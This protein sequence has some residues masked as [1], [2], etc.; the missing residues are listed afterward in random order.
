MNES[1]EPSRDAV[2]VTARLG[3]ISPFVFVSDGTAALTEESV[4][5]YETVTATLAKLQGWIVETLVAD[6]AGFAALMARRAAGELAWD[7]VCPVAA[8]SGRGALVRPVLDGKRPYTMLA[9]AGYPCWAADRHIYTIDLLNPSNE[10]LF[11]YGEDGR[12]LWSVIPYPPRFR[13]PDLV[14]SSLLK[15]VA[16]TLRAEY[17]FGGLWVS[18]AA[19]AYVFPDE[20]KP[21]SRPLHDMVFPHVIARRAALGPDGLERLGKG[22]AVGSR[23]WTLPTCET[24]GDESE[25]VFISCCADYGDENVHLGRAVA[26]ALRRRYVSD[27]LVRSRREA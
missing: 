7:K 19:V 15:A 26:K 14:W 3:P 18:E 1:A 17:A 20:F 4:R 5:L 10:L 8:P 23:K 16:Q 21:L 2:A 22:V 9:R 11:P 13:M 24:F 25:Y 27:E 12:R 6:P